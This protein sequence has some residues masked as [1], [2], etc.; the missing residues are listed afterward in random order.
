MNINEHKFE[1][2]SKQIITKNN[3]L[4][5]VKNGKDCSILK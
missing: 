4:L 1:Q 5:K 2:K 3:L